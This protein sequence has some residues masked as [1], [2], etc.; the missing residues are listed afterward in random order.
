MFEDGELSCYVA[1]AKYIF[2]SCLRFSKFETVSLKSCVSKKDRQLHFD[3]TWALA[4]KHTS[5]IRLSVLCEDSTVSVRSRSVSRIAF[6]L[7]HK[8]KELHVYNDFLVFPKMEDLK[9]TFVKSRVPKIFTGAVNIRQPG[10]V[11]SSTPSESTLREIRSVRSTG[12]HMPARVNSW[13]MS[14][15]ETPFP[16]LSSSLT[17]ER[18]RNRTRIKKCIG[19][20]YTS[21]CVT[22]KILPR[23]S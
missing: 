13:S 19:L 8:E 3:G 21:R 20:L 16:T 23:T 6:G 9:E 4:V 14:V 15:S 12:L 10:P 18:V 7:F 22:C 11:R 17:Q 2:R 1:Y 5:S